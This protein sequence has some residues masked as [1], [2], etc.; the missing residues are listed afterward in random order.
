MECGF[1]IDPDV[2]PDA[3]EYG[4]P[5]CGCLDLDD[6]VLKPNVESERT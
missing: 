1:E 4:C 2:Y 3:E 5:L 6:E